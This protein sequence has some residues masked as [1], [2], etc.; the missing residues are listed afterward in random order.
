MRKNLKGFSKLCEDMSGKDWEL[1]PEWEEFCRLARVGQQA[2]RK[3]VSEKL[4]HYLQDNNIGC[5]ICEHDQKKSGSEECPLCSRGSHFEPKGYLKTVV[6]LALKGRELEEGEDNS[7]NCRFCGGVGYSS[8]FPS[9]PG[10]CAKCGGDGLTD[11]GRKEAKR[12][13]EEGGS[14]EG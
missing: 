8:N 14:D 3:S 10:A 7:Y 13:L 12:R 11:L 1:L 6:E 9:S 5:T 2:E 4:G